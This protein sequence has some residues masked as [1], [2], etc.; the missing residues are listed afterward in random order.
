MTTELK[1]ELPETREEKLIMMKQLCNAFLEYCD[2]NTKEQAKITLNFIQDLSLLKTEDEFKNFYNARP[3][4]DSFEK[5]RNIEYT[6]WMTVVKEVL[7]K[8][9]RTDLFDNTKNYLR[10]IGKIK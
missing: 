6:G 9:V 7:D 3:A 8:I 2:D 4:I 10:S 1:L 5:W